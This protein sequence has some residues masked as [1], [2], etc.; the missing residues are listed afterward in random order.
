MKI[1]IFLLHFNQFDKFDRARRL[2]RIIFFE[3]EIFIEFTVP[4]YCCARE[5]VSLFVLRV[6]RMKWEDIGVIEHFKLIPDLQSQESSIRNCE[7][8]ANLT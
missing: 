7:G 5:E 1:A 4:S 6:L 8:F 2:T 3:V